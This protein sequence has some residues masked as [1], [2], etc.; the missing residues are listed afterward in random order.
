MGRKGG[1][2]AMFTLSAWRGKPTQPLWEYWAGLII[3]VFFLSVQLFYFDGGLDDIFVTI[4]MLHCIIFC[5][6]SLVK[7]YL[8]K[9][10]KNRKNI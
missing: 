9:R 4:L 2:W 7:L 8:A 6:V 1:H 10:Y 5:I 3:A